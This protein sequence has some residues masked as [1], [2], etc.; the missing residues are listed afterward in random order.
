MRKERRKCQESMQNLRSMPNDTEL[1]KRINDA[2]NNI[3]NILTKALGLTAIT[4]FAVDNDAIEIERNTS[5]PCIECDSNSRGRV[6]DG[7][8]EFSTT[9]DSSRTQNITSIQ[10]QVRM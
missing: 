7:R 4:D 9:N 2:H 10:D 5:L 8:C 3:N 6:G 1:C